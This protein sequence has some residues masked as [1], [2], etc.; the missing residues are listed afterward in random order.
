MKATTKTY[1]IDFLAGALNLVVTIHLLNEDVNF[2]I[3]FLTAG[4]GSLIVAL[5]RAR[6][7]SNIELLLR[8]NAGFLFFFLIG[9]NVWIFLLIPIS[10]LG[11]SILGL[12]LKQRQFTAF[13]KFLFAGLGLSIIFFI[14]WKVVPS[15]IQMQTNTN[16]ENLSQKIISNIEVTDLEG[17]PIK[18]DMLK[19]K[20]LV[21]D[22]WATWCK[23]CLQEFEE[24]EEI[25]SM[26][27]RDPEVAFLFI[28]SEEKEKIK[29]FVLKKGYPFT[30]AHDP[31]GQ[32]SRKMQI[33]IL[34]MVLVIDKNDSIRYVHKGYMAGGKFGTKLKEEIESLK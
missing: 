22:F 12:K 14:A 20:V 31:D 23:P 24:I 33:S 29:R 16:V 30:F 34:P 19:N 10:A 25:W 27:E 15:I 18:S 28:S 2:S 3:V 8:L 6:I 11:M 26:Y 32:F 17:D 21:L 5:L 9:M 13:H 1:L 7:D 4:F